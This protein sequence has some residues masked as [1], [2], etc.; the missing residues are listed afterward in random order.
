MRLGEVLPL[1]W[2][3]VNRKAP[4]CHVDDTKAGRLLELP[5]TRQLADSWR[6]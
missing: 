2:E 4:V 5:T 6:T 3:R 1:K